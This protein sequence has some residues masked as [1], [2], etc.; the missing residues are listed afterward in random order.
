MMVVVLRVMGPTCLLYD[1]GS[2]EGN[3]P[4]SLLYEGG[5]TKGTRTN[6]FTV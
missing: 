6:M 3:G 2:T 5:S 4:T 1:G